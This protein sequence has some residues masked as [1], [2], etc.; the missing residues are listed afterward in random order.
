[1]KTSHILGIA[2]LFASL[3]FVLITAAFNQPT[4]SAQNLG[5]AA[6]RLQITPA[7]FE[8]GISEIGST[9]GILIMGFVIMFIIIVPIIIYKNKN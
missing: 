2:F 3:V 4:V 6:F 8:E 1:M 5:A 9:D 7:P